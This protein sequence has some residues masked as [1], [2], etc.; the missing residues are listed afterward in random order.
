MKN[1]TIFSCLIGVV[2]LGITV[3]FYS[4]FSFSTNYIFSSQVYR[5]ENNYIYDVSSY[6]N[7]S[8]YKKYF[9][10]EGYELKLDNINNYV[11]NGSELILLDKNKR[12]VSRFVN[13]I[14]GDIVS[15]GI[16]DSKDINK[17][18]EYLSN[19]YQLKDYEEK[20]MDINNDGSVDIN[21]LNLL[22]SAFNNNIEDI[23]I[24]D[25]KIVLH[26]GE[27]SRIIGRVLPGYGVNMN[28]VYIN[29]NEDII[30]VD[31]SGKIVGKNLGSS[32]VFVYDY[33]KKIEKKVNIVVDNRIRLSS[34][35][36][37]IFVSDMETVVDI[38]S[39]S[40]RDIE[41]VSSNVDIANCRVDKD[42]LYIK[43]N[44]KGNALVRVISKEYGEVSY[45]LN[46]YDSY[47]DFIPNYYCFQAKNNEII[48]LEH[49]YDNVEI[50]NNK[51]ISN[52]YIEGNLLYLKGIKKSGREELVIKSDDGEKKIII[53]MV[54]LSVPSIGGIVNV[55]G[56]GSADI[57]FN[58]INELSCVTEDSNIADCYI[59]DN[60]LYFKGLKKGQ[61]NVEIINTS[62]YGNTQYEC[63]KTQFLVVVR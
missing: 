10:V 52:A 33:D 39:I 6:T 22:E 46:S 49:I 19:N 1:K 32:S 59:E 13:I 2:V 38:K 42:K 57:V 4:N 7:V 8:L 58:N 9:D 14:K 40:Y 53:D 5:I 41:C 26:V 23:D 45:S 44:K 60:K 47:L 27:E 31:E 25:E 15:D 51:L 62:S 54:S 24:N 35:S 20:S 16:I 37:D 48:N 56:I 21:D 36:G 12:E 3:L 11:Y 29:N 63:G 18:R 34:N 50:Y 17:F 55:G 28:L 43:A 61:V 30:S